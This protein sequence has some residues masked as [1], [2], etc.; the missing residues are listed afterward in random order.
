METDHV[1]TEDWEERNER[2]A[3]EL[4]KNC[5]KNAEYAN[6]NNATKLHQNLKSILWTV[7]GDLY[8]RKPKVE[9]V[10]GALQDPLE[11]L[12]NQ[13]AKHPLIPQLRIAHL[14]G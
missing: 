13:H 3:K 7:P 1:S 2:A 9:R 5:V 10:R 11:L 4:S 12:K 14:A 8:T 6:A